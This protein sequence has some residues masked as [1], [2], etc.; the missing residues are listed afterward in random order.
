MANSIPLIANQFLW[1][2]GISCM[3]EAIWFALQGTKASANLAMHTAI[4]VR[5]QY[6]KLTWW[7]CN[8]DCFWYMQRWLQ[9]R[10]T[11]YSIEMMIIQ[12]PCCPNWS[13][14]MAFWV[15]AWARSRNLWEVLHSDHRNSQQI[16]FRAIWQKVLVWQT[17]E[18]HASLCRA[19]M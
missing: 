1:K 18:K 6:T 14:T 13:E 11:P 17:L 4:S 8:K 16:C 15:M 19:T 5:N 12:I 10:I 3:S 7:H 9:S 2:G